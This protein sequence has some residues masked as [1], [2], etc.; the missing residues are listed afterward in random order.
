MKTCLTVIGLVI[1]GVLL[2]LYE[3]WYL[4]HTWN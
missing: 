1:L 3:V 4:K 2:V